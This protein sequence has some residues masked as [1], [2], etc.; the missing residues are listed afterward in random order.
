LKQSKVIVV[1]QK[2]VRGLLAKAHLRKLRE[3]K[4]TQI[5]KVKPALSHKNIDNQIGRSQNTQNESP[6]SKIQ[7]EPSSYCYSKNI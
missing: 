7:R 4:A 3:N 2:H 5:I 6:A 1:I